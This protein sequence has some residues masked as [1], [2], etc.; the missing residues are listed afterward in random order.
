MSI[1]Y[2]TVVWPAA[3]TGFDW[4]TP[5]LVL[6]GETAADVASIPLPTSL[7]RVGNEVMPFTHAAMRDDFGP[8]PV[9]D[10]WIAAVEGG[11][12]GRAKAV[13]ALDPLPAGVSTNSVPVEEGVGGEKMPM[14]LGPLLAGA[15]R[16]AIRDIDV[17]VGIDPG[18]VMAIMIDPSAPT[19]LPDWAEQ[20]IGG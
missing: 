13:V 8:I 15:V 7:H 6:A 10:A 9:S 2:S 11:Y 18:D 4:D 16:V 5:L 17:S 1:H 20:M 12:D 19:S 3:E 14:W